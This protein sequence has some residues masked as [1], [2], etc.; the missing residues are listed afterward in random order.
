MVIIAVFLVNLTEA[1]TIWE[2]RNSN[3]KMSPTNLPVGKPVCT[4][5]T[6]IDLRW[7]N[8]LWLVSCV[9]SLEVFKQTVW[10]KPWWTWSLFGFLPWLSWWL[11]LRYMMKQNFSSPS[12]FWYWCAI[13]A[14]KNLTKI[15][16]LKTFREAKA[17]K[18]GAK[19]VAY[20]SVFPAS[21]YLRKCCFC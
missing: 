7:P 15:L 1:R 8:L 13:T 9:S 18:Q 17:G 20:A 12:F 14:A 10:A 3:E 6:T 19:V 2:E 16:Y 5:L 11:T 4:L 21:S